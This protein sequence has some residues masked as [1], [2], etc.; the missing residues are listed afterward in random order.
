MDNSFTPRQAKTRLFCVANKDMGSFDKGDLEDDVSA[1]LET[2]LKSSLDKMDIQE[3]ALTTLKDLVLKFRNTYECKYD[4][5]QKNLHAETVLTTYPS[6]TRTFVQNVMHRFHSLRNVK[7]LHT[8]FTIQTTSYTWAGRPQVGKEKLTNAEKEF[9][10]NFDRANDYDKTLM[11]KALRIESLE[12]VKETHKTAL[13]VV[14]RPDVV[15]VEGCPKPTDDINAQDLEELLL[16]PSLPDQVFRALHSGVMPCLQKERQ[17]KDVKSKD[18]D[19]KSRPQINLLGLS[20]FWGHSDP[21]RN[22]F[23]AHLDELVDKTQEYFVGKFDTAA[24]TTFSRKRPTP[25][26]PG[27]SPTKS[28]SPKKPRQGRK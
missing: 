25:E 28:P 9:N 20:I 11:V 27:T 16:N 19:K 2:A 5:S 13:H 6:Y 15:L 4:T 22:A 10:L 26:S 23:I 21:S 3:G 24:K 8:L 18:K 17:D 12:I 14:T 1:F 7:H